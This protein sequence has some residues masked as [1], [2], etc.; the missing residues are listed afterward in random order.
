MTEDRNPAQDRIDTA[1]GGISRLLKEL[2]VDSLELVRELVDEALEEP[3]PEFAGPARSGSRLS[4]EI[5]RPVR[6]GNG[7]SPGKGRGG[8]R[9]EGSTAR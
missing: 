1:V 5:S 4:E 9:E 8:N 2:P 7:S 6:A 3:A